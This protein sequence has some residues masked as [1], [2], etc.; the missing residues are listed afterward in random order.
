[1]SNSYAATPTSGLRADALSGVRTRR[2]LALCVDLVIVGAMAFALWLMLL[3]LTLGLSLFLLPPLFPLVAFLYN[4]L[5]IS[6]RR[7]ATPGMRAF[8]LEMRLHDSGAR[9]PF[10]N[11]A[12]HAVF[13]YISWA[14]PPVFLVSLVEL[15]KAMP[16]RYSRRGRDSAPALRSER[17]RAG[18][19]LF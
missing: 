5:S 13:F 10:I 11:A 12:A 9:T 7:M 15:G 6:G 8:D 1:M 18:R 14:F 4:G 17:R 3:V 2:I 16:A 19:A